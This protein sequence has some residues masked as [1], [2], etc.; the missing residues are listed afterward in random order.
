MLICENNIIQN[1]VGMVH[2]V[3]L[4]S[5]QMAIISTF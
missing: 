5:Y 1:I 2:W 3:P 4:E